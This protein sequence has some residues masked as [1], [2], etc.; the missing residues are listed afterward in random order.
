MKGCPSPLLLMSESAKL[1]STG[2]DG[3]RCTVTEPRE[4]RDA[5]WCTKVRAVT[6]APEYAQPVQQGPVGVVRYRKK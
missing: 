6:S 1:V 4:Q 3:T 2:N 5:R